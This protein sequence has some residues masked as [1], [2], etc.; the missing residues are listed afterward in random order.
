MKL[1]SEEQDSPQWTELVHNGCLAQSISLVRCFAPLL[2]SAAGLSK[3][4]SSMKFSIGRKA[5]DIIASLYIIG[6]LFLRLQLEH[7]LDGRYFLSI[8]LGLFGLLFLWALVKIGLLN[9]SFFGMWP[10]EEAERSR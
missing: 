9:P 7:Q 1:G 6:T 8:A 4:T 3:K 10:G 5:S 2:L